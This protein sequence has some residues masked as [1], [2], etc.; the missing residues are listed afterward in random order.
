MGISR[1]K[2]HKRRATGGKRAPIRMKRKFELGRQPAMTK[3][4]ERRVHQVRA[5]GG[6]IKFRA[7]KLDHGNY[8]WPG[9]AVTRKSRI[10]SVV[11]NPTNP[12]YVR[13]NTVVKGSIVQIDATPFKNWYQKHYGVVI[14]K[15]IKFHKEK[16]STE[17]K[18]RKHRALVPEKPKKVS[19]A[20]VEKK[21]DKKGDKKPA[22]TEKG[23]KAGD[24]KTEEKKPEAK[25]AEKVK[26]TVAKPNAKIGTAVV[27][28]KVVKKVT[29]KV[30]PKKDE[31]KVKKEKKC[32]ALNNSRAKSAKHRPSGAMLKKWRLRNVTRVLEAAVAE[33][34]EKGRLFAKV[35]TS[36]GQIGSAD[37]YILEG[38][39]L[40]FYVKKMQAKKKK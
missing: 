23:K 29:K 20:K 40:A 16:K 30:A 1:D 17:K 8:A 22:K 21:G 34:F 27:E 6:F 38:E 4:G 32:K 10:I 28:T 9:E 33:Q 19:E 12:E 26:K 36:P 24:K 35:A 37:G 11:Y 31:D 3:L 5:R 18:S 13:T 2:W 39:E 15:A 25:P 14:G 7:M